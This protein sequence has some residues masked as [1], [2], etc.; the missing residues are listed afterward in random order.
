MTNRP[1]TSR[2]AL[3]SNFRL[4][5]FGPALL[6][7]LTAIAMP[8]MQ[9][10]TLHVLYALTDTPGGAN[11]TRLTFDGAGNLYGATSGGPTNG[12]VFELRHEGSSW[13]F[14][15]L[16]NFQPHNDGIAPGPVV[17]GPDGALYGTTDE[18]GLPCYYQFAQCGTVYSLRPSPDP[19]GSAICLWNETRI[20]WFGAF[21][22]ISDGSNPGYGPL[23]FDPTGNIYGTTIFG[24]L[25]GQGTAF[26]LVKTQNGW[27]EHIIANFT[28][29]GSPLNAISGLTFNS[30]GNLFGTIFMAG[31]F[32]QVFELTPSGQGWNEQAIYSFQG[33]ND[34]AYPLGG[35]IFDAAGNAYGS[36]Y[37]PPGTVFQLSPQQDGSW[38]ET[39]L[40]VLA[41]IN[42]PFYGPESNLAMDASGNLYGTTPGTP[43]SQEDHNGMVFKL[44]QVDGSWTFTQLYEFTGGDDGSFPVGGVIVDS[45]GN[46]YGACTTGGANQRGTIWEITP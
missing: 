40:H 26:Q 19:C 35:L 16:Y 12:G 27:T 3:C 9:A 41:G 20:H 39:V 1:G 37:E 32:G 45:A 4:L 31:S 13:I 21:D 5:A 43:F 7:A 6:C 18:G 8:S 25:H 10:Q 33:G 30:A 44:S 15:P 36:T 14:Q 2:T 38:R 34:G 46:L 22:N 17:F 29:N 42:G 23:I 28:S 11:P 24:G